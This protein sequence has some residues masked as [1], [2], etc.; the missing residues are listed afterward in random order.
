M[1]GI[2]LPHMCNA[3][4]YRVAGYFED[5]AGSRSFRNGALPNSVSHL[6]TLNLALLFSH[7]RRQCRLVLYAV[8]LV[9]FGLNTDGGTFLLAGRS[10][11]LLLLW[12][13][14]YTSLR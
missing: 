11:A 4:E 2:L 13:V 14:F 10:S 1:N 9:S 6:I 3:R 5:G 7:V 12:L 8:P